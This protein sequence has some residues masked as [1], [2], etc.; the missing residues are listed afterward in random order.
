MSNMK[1]RIENGSIKVY[2]AVPRD[3]LNI[4]NFRKAD[5]EVH[6]SHGFYDLVAPEFDPDYWR[7]GRLYF[8]AE[9]QIFTYELVQVPVEEVQEKLI[10]DFDL[11]KKQTRTELLEALLD[12]MIELHREEL[13]E[14]LVGLWDALVSENDRVIQTIDDLAENDPDTLRKFRIRQED[15]E[16]FLN[17]IRRFKV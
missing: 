2:D 14:G 11:A 9:G 13:P 16:E 3:Y 4:L 6:K 5:A 7:L 12:K 1:A 15:V 17:N 10:H 8:D